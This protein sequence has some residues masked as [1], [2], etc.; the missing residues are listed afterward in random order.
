MGCGSF[1]QNP[2]EKGRCWGPGQGTIQAVSRQNDTVAKDGTLPQ[3]KN[4]RKGLSR[5]K[6]GLCGRNLDASDVKSYTS[7]RLHSD[8]S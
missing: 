5:K 3:E 7:V 4:Y 1:Q 2:P 6:R 8:S